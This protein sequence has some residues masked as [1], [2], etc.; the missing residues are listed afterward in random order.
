MI[1]LI[2]SNFWFVYVISEA[3]RNYLRGCKFQNFPT[4]DPST[5]GALLHAS[6][7]P[8]YQ[9]NPMLIPDIHVHVP[10]S[11]WIIHVNIYLVFMVQ[12]PATCL[13]SLFIYVESRSRDVETILHVWGYRFD[14]KYVNVLIS[15]NQSGGGA[16]SIHV[17]VWVWWIWENMCM[18][19]W[20]CMSY[21]A[22]HA[23][24]YM[25]MHMYK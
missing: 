9:K 20:R 2:C 22:I 4:P 13:Y 21:M 23:H 17:Q 6:I 14:T 8:L 15:T 5:L 19:L 18:P 1:K 3:T 24:M 12:L 10:I 11:H 7:S 25:Y 16:F